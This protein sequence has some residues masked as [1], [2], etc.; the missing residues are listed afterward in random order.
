MRYACS[1]A[2]LALVW[3][4]EESR[5]RENVPTAPKP[6]PVTRAVTPKREVVV[7]E[8]ISGRVVDKSGEGI[9]GLRIWIVDKETGQV[10][11][12]TRTGDKGAFAM[13]IAAAESLIVRMS[14]E[15]KEFVE[16]EYTLEEF[17]TSEPE[18]VFAP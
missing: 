4:Q 5:A 3:A 9:K 2:L 14:R 16:R 18:I 6:A 8:T 15:G 17:T 7:M 12:E 1:L 11:G 10:L 13:A